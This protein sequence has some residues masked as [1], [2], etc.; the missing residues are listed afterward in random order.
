MVDS[1]LLRTLVLVFMHSRIQSS[2]SL[3]V[4]W[5]RIYFSWILLGQ[6]HENS[7]RDNSEQAKS[8]AKPFRIRYASL[9]S[10]RILQFLVKRNDSLRIVQNQ[11]FL[12][13][14]EL[15]IY[16]KRIYFFFSTRDSYTGV[17][18]TL[19]IDITNSGICYESL[20]AMSIL[21]MFR[22][23]VYRVRKDISRDDTHAYRASY[24]VIVHS[25]RD[26]LS[27]GLETQVEAIE[28][29]EKWSM[30]KWSEEGGFFFFRTSPRREC[31][32][33]RR[34]SNALFPYISVLFLF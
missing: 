31:C 24:R 22:T 32:L 21:M 27:G 23:I 33:L 12:V 17:V 9:A 2:W 7:F 10:L 3:A 4:C 20:E 18:S 34:A 28:F 13:K 6:V 25:I 8:F 26:E 29:L 11:Q 19:T 14:F 1:T 5:L 30:R 15:K 16:K